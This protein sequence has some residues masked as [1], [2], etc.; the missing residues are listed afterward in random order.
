MTAIAAG[1]INEPH[2]RRVERNRN[3]RA[4]ADLLDRGN[5][6]ADEDHED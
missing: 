5:A 3:R 1:T 2:E 6:G 4:K